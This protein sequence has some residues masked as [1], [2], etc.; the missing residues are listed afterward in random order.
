M[1]NILKRKIGI[2]TFHNVNNYGAQL[3]AFAL[4]SKCS[5]FCE[6]VDIIN[7][8]EQGKNSGTSN[9]KL[10]KYFLSFYYDNQFFA[11]KY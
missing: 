8:I 4:Q 6:R 11:G 5:E 1:K 7:Y 3:Q 10:Y 9:N 2:M